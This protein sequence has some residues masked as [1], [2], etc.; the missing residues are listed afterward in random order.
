VY[1]WGLRDQNISL[2]QIE[3]SS[4]V[5]CWAAK[6]YGKSKVHFASEQSTTPKR[7]LKGIHDMLD[8][9]DAVV[10]YNGTSFDIPT[11]NKEFIINR[12]TPPAP[13]K[14]VDLYR[15]GKGAFRFQSHKLDYITQTL[16]IGSK[17]RHEGQELWTKCM[18]G[19][20][21]AWKRMR[22][23]NIQDVVLLEELYER[24]LPWIKGHPNL[25]AYSGTVCC[26]RSA[27]HKRL[28]KRGTAC[29]AQGTYERFQCLEPG[30]GAWARGP[31]T[32]YSHDKM[33]SL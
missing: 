21:A 5:L 30:C 2:N 15:V 26:P 9:A 28:Q 7:M 4:R 3:E 11:L 32:K 29:N 24:V 31:V 20:R 14:Q 17:I 1:T 16:G 27:K 10:H 6:W 8:E 13:Y 33:V 12:M 18:K 22:A 19:D 23:Y 25:S